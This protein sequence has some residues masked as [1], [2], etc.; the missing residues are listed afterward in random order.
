MDVPVAGGM[1]QHPILGAVRSTARAPD[2]MMVVP[3][4]QD[5]NGLTTYRAATLLFTPE[6]K[7]LPSGSEGS[8]H[9]YAQ[10]GGKIALTGRAIGIRISF[11][12]D[13]P[14]NRR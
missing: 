7:R 14:S 6:E 2:D 9:L 13:M 12:F 5:G 3:S 4:C 1:Q 8:R 11:Y 10:A